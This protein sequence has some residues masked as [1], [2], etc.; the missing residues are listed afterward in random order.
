MRRQMFGIIIETA[1]T[2]HIPIPTGWRSTY[3]V[4]TCHF[5]IRQAATPTLRHT[6][7]EVPNMLS[8]TKDMVGG[9]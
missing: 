8:L 9:D 2:K 6:S 3:R 7:N 4:V 5:Q 1:E